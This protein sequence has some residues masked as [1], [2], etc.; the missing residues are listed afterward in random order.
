MTRFWAPSLL[1]L[2]ALP[3]SANTIILISNTSVTFFE[4]PTFG[5][6]SSG[7]LNTDLN[8]NPASGSAAVALSPP[9][10]AY[11]TNTTFDTGSGSSAV[12]IGVASDAGT[13]NSAGFTALYA[14]TFTLT[15]AVASASLALDYAV[16]NQLGATN[17]GVYLNG[18]ALPGSTGIGGFASLNTYSDASIGSL[19]KV[20]SN[21]LYFNDVNTGTIQTAAGLI[22]AAT[23]TVNPVPEPATPGMVAAG[24]AAL[25]FARKRRAR[26][27]T[28]P[29]TSRLP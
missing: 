18:T 20:G 13:N 3:A 22:F 1:V 15:Q 21:T 25:W 27:S 14:V 8:A 17:A 12:W 16:D 28:N 7:T 5:D 6:F 24:L 2:A 11:V 9:N 26:L 4:G 23:L 10:A 19:L 29:G